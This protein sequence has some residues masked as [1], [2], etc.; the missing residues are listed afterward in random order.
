MI[1]IK[2]LKKSY[3]K[4]EVLHGIDLELGQGVY[5]LLGPNGAGKTTL[6]NIVV[7]LIRPSS[8]NVLIDGI[9]TQRAGSEHLKKLGFLPQS[10]EYY[11][12]FTAREFM[13]YM[14]ALKGIKGQNDEQ[15]RD[16]LAFVNLSEDADRR[17]GAFSGGML[18]RVGLAQA[19]LG[20]PSVVILDEPTA[21]LDPIERIRFRNLISEIS[22][23]RT[24]IVAT[25]IVPDIEYI[26]NS[27]I[28]LFN[29]SIRRQGSPKD[30]CESVN[31]RVWQV[32][33]ELEKAEELVKR[34]PVSNVYSEENF[35]TLR[36]AADSRPCNGAE[37]V[38][39]GLEDVF[40]CEARR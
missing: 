2:G 24:L 15:I 13:C 35:C 38:Y 32:K 30:L 29:G 9:S 37:Q 22:R 8:G 25:H 6:M 36:I 14:S 23:G 27:V 5:G 17:L 16:L 3:G 39:P 19:L 4:K 26:A 28:L 34:F 18:R 1:E 20:D 40:L 10:P 12:N 21:G 31:G 7:G 33:T 11:K